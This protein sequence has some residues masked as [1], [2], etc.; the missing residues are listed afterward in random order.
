MAL[1]WQQ[2]GAER[3]HLIDLDG[4]FSG[5]SAH[6]DLAESIFRALAIPVQF[7]GGV[8]TLSQVERILE[9]GAKR[10]ILGSAAVENPHLVKEAVDRFPG[11]VV[12]GI[13]ARQ[14]MA[15]T[16][17]WIRKSNLSALELARRMKALGVERIIYADIAR[18]G[19]L[20]GV[21]VEETR[22]LAQGADV[23][24]LASGGVSSLNDV[25]ELWKCR[26][27][28]IEGAILGRALYEGKLDFMELKSQLRAW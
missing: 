10:V 19:L 2:Q 22:E 18:D 21:N 3:L 4:A 11:A 20:T 8:R 24:V 16:H 5:T 17:G 6:L 13:D 1:H 12:I 14:G 25:R 26:T 23:R 27:A 9:L 28:G 15:A 7:G